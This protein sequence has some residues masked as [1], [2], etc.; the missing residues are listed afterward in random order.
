MLFDFIDL[1]PI[2]YTY[3]FFLDFSRLNG[4]FP[5]FLPPLFLW[6]EILAICWGGVGH[7]IVDKRALVI[8]FTNISDY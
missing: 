3:M 1:P 2:I 7:D 5:P 4:T 8:I 6:A